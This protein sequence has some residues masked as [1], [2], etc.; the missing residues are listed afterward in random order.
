[1]E[2]ST[3][4]Q[5]IDGLD[6]WKVEDAARSLKDAQKIIIDKK[7]LKAAKKLLLQEQKATNKAVD[8]TNNI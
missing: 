1:M 2:V 7:L 8:W 6:R 4:S 3:T 5:K